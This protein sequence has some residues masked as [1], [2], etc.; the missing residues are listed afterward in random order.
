MKFVICFSVVLLATVAFAGSSAQDQALYEELIAKY[1]SGEI[2]W[3]PAHPSQ[4]QFYGMP[5]EQMRKHL[6]GVIPYENSTQGQQNNL[7]YGSSAWDI[8]SYLSL[9]RNFDWRKKSPGCINPIR[10]QGNCG[11]CWA[12]A[13]SE[14][15][16]DRYCLQSNANEKTVLSPQYLVSCVSSNNIQGCNGAVMY[17]VFKE[18]ENE[19]TVTNAC[20]PYTSGDSAQNGACPSSCTDGSAFQYYKCKPG[21]V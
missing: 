6:L 13:V 3:K 21:T 20:V 17:Y 1:D 12:F 9:P 5:S 2:S 18:L 15:L 14:V 11:S 4:N 8:F 7:E 16:S 19:G 10:N